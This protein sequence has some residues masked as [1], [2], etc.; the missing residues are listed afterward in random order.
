MSVA[1][2]K[3]SLEELDK[4]FRTI[5]DAEK[6]FLVLQDRLEVLLKKT[7][8]L[9]EAERAPLL[10]L[11]KNFQQYLKEHLEDIQRQAAVLQIDL[12]DKATHVKAARAYGQYQK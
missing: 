2:L 6:D 8:E 11:L 5:P 3:K 12:Q 10:P 7:T 1:H 9:S 4:D